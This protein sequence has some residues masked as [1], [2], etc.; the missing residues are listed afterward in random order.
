MRKIALIIICLLSFS[1]VHVS[2][3]S[4][5]TKKEL[6]YEITDIV[7]KEKEIVV[8][9]WGFL[10]YEQHFYNEG[11]HR[12]RLELSNGKEVIQI[13]GTIRNVSQTK[14]MKPGGVRKCRWNEYHKTGNTC[15]YDL[16]NVGFE[17]HIPYSKIKMNETYECN[18]II[19]GLTSNRS[20]K[21]KL[22]FPLNQPKLKQKEQIRYQVN[23]ELYDTKIKVEF[24]SVYVRPVPNDFR[25]FYRK[26]RACSYSYGNTLYFK[27]G[28]VFSHVLERRLIGDTNFY[29]VSSADAGC[30]NGM[31]VAKE[32]N[33]Y[34][35]SW[36]PSTFVSYQGKPLTVSSVLINTPPVITI[37]KHP[38]IQEGNKLN[39][40][41]YVSAYDKEEGD[42]TNKIKHISGIVDS[43]KKGIYKIVY[44]VEDKYHSKDR[45]TL[46]VTVNEAENHAPVIDA[47]NRTVY[48]YDH[49]DYLEGV[50]VY[51][52]EDKDIAKKLTY[53]GNVDTSQLGTYEVTYQ[54]KD[55]KGAKAEKTVQINV[56][57]NPSSY[58][59]FLDR[60]KPF[61]K[62][63]LPKNWKDKSILL[64][65]QLNST[66][67]LM[68][69]N[70]VK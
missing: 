70:F 19:D 43:N 59:R 56:V 64:K 33:T 58:I 15:Y 9:G 44:E 47:Q 52:K 20:R 17:F 48:Q 57:R 62:Q 38:V 35:P 31:K 12:Y 10:S 30:V 45:K 34:H 23:S 26:G 53:Q 36:I 1:F 27:K 41:D 66:T 65:D 13:P 67:V 8:K 63:S 21:I 54:V 49:F 51:D 60:N 14:Y 22:Y 3:S 4:T 25:Y 37:K 42:L 55:N 46:Q 6:P 5:A 69:S 68:K 61:Y 50:E 7:M 11:T 16:E 40:L 24:D 18:L 39:P 2:A 32:G 28:E 29:R